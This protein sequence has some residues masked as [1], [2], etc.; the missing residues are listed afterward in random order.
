[1]YIYSF[2]LGMAD[3]M[4]SLTFPR[5]TAYIR[6]YCVGEYIDLKILTDLHIFIHSEYGNIVSEM[7]FC[8]SVCL[9][10]RTC[11]YIYMCVCV[12]VE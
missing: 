3:T 8:L 2:L 5:G 1:M 9:S 10:E 4:T 6:R 12:C 11:E 7:P